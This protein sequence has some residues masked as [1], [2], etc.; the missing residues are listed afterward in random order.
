MPRPKVAIKIGDGVMARWPGSAKFYPAK[1]LDQDEE[2]MEVQFDEGTIY[3]VPVLHV[4]H[5]SAF[6]G[7]SKSKSPARSKPKGSPNRLTRKTRSR[8]KSPKHPQVQKTNPSTKVIEASL[9]ENEVKPSLRA[10]A[11]GRP[12]E[13]FTPTRSSA[14]I[15]EAIQ[16]RD[17]PD[18]MARTEELLP[19]SGES[20]A[21]IDLIETKRWKIPWAKIGLT[22]FVGAI[23]PLSAAFT[24]WLNMICGKG[25]CT[26]RM[27]KFTKNVGA[28]ITVEAMM[29]YAGFLLFQTL[30]ICLP[31][32]KFI[33]GLP[34]HDGSCLKYRLNGLHSFAVI[35]AILAAIGAYGLPVNY[36][37]R[38]TIPLISAS[39]LCAIIFSLYLFLRACKNSSGHQGNVNIERN[40]IIRYFM[41]CELNPRI[42][43][44]DVKMLLDG[45]IGLNSWAVVILC[46]ALE[47]LKG[48]ISPT[49]LMVS[50]LQLLYIF[51]WHWYENTMLTMWE[52]KNE[53][54]G[55]MLAFGNMTM[56][57]F[58]FSIPVRYLFFHHSEL[59]PAYLV[60][61]LLLFSVGYVILRNSNNQ[62]DGFRRDPYH[63][64]F[65]AMRTFSMDKSQK[66][67][68]DGWWQ[69]VRHPN[70]V[71]D[72]MIAAAFSVACGFQHI[73]PHVYFLY[74]LPFLV[75]RA[76]RVEKR[77][78]SKYGSQWT[79][80]CQEVKYRMIPYVY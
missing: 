49:L 5:K 44:L 80:Y 51:H 46:Y 21:E 22:C 54:V 10:R 55:F 25:G 17:R 79:E 19:S 78:S 12:V 15:A 69:V 1:V 20:D 73:V 77:C 47:N 30:L 71:G 2:E 76:W 40:F 11:R 26:V 16:V 31:I 65:S 39:T 42:G 66:I 29:A 14:R 53:A 74:L 50:S 8:S 56:V 38:N 23:M 35:I 27:P 52:F 70:Y 32:G 18:Y 34:Q 72:L 9:L 24:F 37:A 41:G 3:F 33:E 61:S 48:Q 57:P 68:A 62:K 7:R 64:K 63:P 43:S 75:V 36:L 67:L 28:Y 6:R 60:A 45:R 59:E 58:L 4:K 13:K